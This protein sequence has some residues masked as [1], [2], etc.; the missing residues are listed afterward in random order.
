MD[1]VKH[2]LREY[3]MNLSDSDDWEE[4]HMGGR[5][6]RVLSG[7]VALRAFLGIMLWFRDSWNLLEILYYIFNFL[8][9]LVGPFKRY[10]PNS[11]FRSE[12]LITDG[13]PIGIPIRIQLLIS[14]Y[15][16]SIG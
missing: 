5:C 12:F 9:C 3:L 8:A 10:S 11:E 4:G 13:I 16:A 2:Q 1:K 14:I 6:D 15:A 7:E